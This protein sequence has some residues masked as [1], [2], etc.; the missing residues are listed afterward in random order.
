[1]VNYILEKRK[2]KLFYHQ[3]T[4]KSC[5]IGEAK[6]IFFTIIINGY[7]DQLIVANC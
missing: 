1:M 5:G 2:K 3:K 7:K 6:T 4:Q